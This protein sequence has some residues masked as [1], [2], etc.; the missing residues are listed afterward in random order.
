MLRPKKAKQVQKALRACDAAFK[1][2][3]AEATKAQ[4]MLSQLSKG[5]S[6]QQRLDV[7]RQHLRE[8]AAQIVYLKARIDVFNALDEVSSGTRPANPEGRSQFD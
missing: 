6:T 2:Y 8:N 4:Q 5:V 1:L 3:I 7:S